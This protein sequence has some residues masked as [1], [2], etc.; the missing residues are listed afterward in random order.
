MK[1]SYEWLK[2]YIGA[3]MPEVSKLEELLT[4]HAFEVDGI[5]KVGEQTV[6]DVKVLPDR[7]S[8]CLSHLGIAREI[9]ALIGTPLKN[10]PFRE[11]V[12][13]GPRTDKL[14][15]HIHNNQACRRFTAA[16]I[17]GVTVGPSPEWLRHRL[18]S[19][20]QRSINNVVDATNYVMFSLGQPLH[21]YDGALFPHT[22]SGWHFG[23]RMARDGEQV[24]TLSNET[25]T[26]QEAVQ[27]IV[28]E[29]SDQPVGIAGIKGGKSA[30]ITESTTTII[31][32]AANFDPVVTRKS[33]QYL[34][35]QTDA[36]KRFENDIPPQLTEYGLSACVTLILDIAGGTLDGYVGEEDAT[37]ENPRVTVS[38]ALIPRLLGVS[39]SDAQIELLFDRLQFTYIH[40]E[41]GWEVVAPFFRT[42][43]C[44]P[45][46]IIAEVGRLYG[47]EHI[48]PVVPA[49]VPLVEYNAR[50]FYCEKIRTLLA[51]NGFSE[52]I[53]SSFRKKDTITLQNALASDKGCLR[54][55]LRENIRE[56]LVRNMP[57]V[58]L[59]GLSAVR[60]FEIGSVFQK[61]ATNDDVIEYV[62]LAIG[63]Q[64]KQGGYIPKD[65]DA[66]QAIVHA[67]E[68]LL[69]V[70][71]E[72]TIDRGVYTAQ[73][74]RAFS[75]LPQPTTYDAYQKSEDTIFTPYST[76]PF[77]ARDI[78][79]WGNG[80]TTVTDIEKLFRE[81][82]GTLLIHVK[83]F[84]TFTKESRTSYAWRLIFQSFERTLTDDE[85]NTIMERIYTI[86][87][88][89]G[90]ETR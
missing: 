80:S 74:T 24:T 19:I 23:V 51:D 43:I 87:R 21:A 37:P 47:Y 63:V 48:E 49:R 26:L 1:V 84:D 42:D 38:K 54:S 22:E 78:A 76:F 30:E 67:I 20:G 16:L 75:Q 29:K 61:N 27:L 90:Y 10:D 5:E 31:L 39:I 68:E 7:S 86:L 81:I 52:V 69:G 12:L 50:H 36:G 28:D 77:I 4:F 64:Q 58:D 40:T 62:E 18:E 25:Y 82:A 35:L 13:L 85:V 88:A 44:I 46:D 73:V 33:S 70:S 17:S 6:I 14:S 53:T 83:L 72:G 15:V 2:E 56:V 57:N 8:D 45:E 41:G 66:L 55:T 9:S 32:E 11:K 3:E 59:L 60:V 71:L 34:R 89:Q 65:D 79:F